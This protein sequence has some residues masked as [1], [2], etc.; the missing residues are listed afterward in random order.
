MK[1]CKETDE[2]DTSLEHIIEEVYKGLFSK[3]APANIRAF[4]DFITAVNKVNL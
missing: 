4:S 3:T 2:N 1:N